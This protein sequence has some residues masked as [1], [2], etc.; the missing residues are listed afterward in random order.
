M[1]RPN[2]TGYSYIYKIP[3]F[4][5]SSSLKFL[6]K[7]AIIK[8]VN[9]I[10]AVNKACDDYLEVSYVPTLAHIADNLYLKGEQIKQ[11]RQ[12]IQSSARKQLSLFDE[13]QAS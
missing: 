8:G 6:S 11:R 13:L 3:D 7:N 9:P 2:L 4:H 10:D 5:V 1:L 12:K